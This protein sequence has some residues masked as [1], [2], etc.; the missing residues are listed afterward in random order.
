MISP[1]R[2]HGTQSWLWL[3]ACLGFV[4]SGLISPGLFA[5][6][7]AQTAQKATTEL[8]SLLLVNGVIYTGDPARSRV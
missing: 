8:P 3:I 1:L 4:S 7:H 6:R 2:R 5:A